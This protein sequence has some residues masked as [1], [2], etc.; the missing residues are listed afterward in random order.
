MHKKN[1]FIAAYSSTGTI[2]IFDLVNE[3]ARSVIVAKMEA[4][5]GIISFIDNQKLAL[6]TKSGKLQILNVHLDIY[7]I[8]KGNV[9]SLQQ[10]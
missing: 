5:E 1:Q 9:I 8:E 7:T 6:V 2:H 4:E 10:L 3:S